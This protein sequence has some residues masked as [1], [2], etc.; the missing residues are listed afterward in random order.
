MLKHGRGS[1]Q[2]AAAKAGRSA[3]EA[4][5]NRGRA[6]PDFLAT[7]SSTLGDAAGARIDGAISAALARIAGF[8]DVDL[9]VLYEVGADAML[10]LVHYAGAPFHAPAIAGPSVSRAFPW[11]LDR[12]ARNGEMLCIN[13]IADIPG[14]AEKDRQSYARR[15][16]KAAVLIPLSAIRRC[17][18]VLAIVS[19]RPER[20]RWTR[21]DTV[22]LRATGEP[23]MHAVTRIKLDHAQRDV[24]HF[25]RF[26][27]RLSVRFAGV[28]WNRVCDEIDLALEEVLAYC[29]VDEVCIFE[30]IP[31]TKQ[32]YLRHLA[33]V[34]GVKPASK[35]LDYGALFPWQAVVTANR[36]EMTDRPGE[37]AHDAATGRFA[38]EALSMDSVLDMPI[39][40]NDEVRYVFAVASRRKSHIWAQQCIARLQT[41]G[42]V[43]INALTRI[44][45]AEAL[46]QSEQRLRE[47]MRIAHIARWQWDA[48]TDRIESSGDV[49]RIIGFEP[50]TLTK[51]M[52]SV[53]PAHRL[54]LQRSI[55]SACAKCG[56]RVRTEYIVCD[57][58]GERIIQ[59]WHEA[60]LSPNGE[61]CI[62]N[63]TIQDVTEWRKTE[64]EVDDLRAHHW[65]FDR[66]SRT[67]ILVASLAHELS[68][69]L[70]AVLSNAQA[71]LR[72]L[73]HAD[74]DPDEIRNI[75]VDIVAADKRA[76]EVLGALRAMLRRQRTKRSSLDISEAVREVL[77]LLHGELVT[78]QVQV[79]TELAADCFV[80][81]D[82]IQ[83]EQV[84]LNLLMNAVDSMR[85]QASQTRRLRL[86]VF[87]VGDDVSVAVSD[88]GIGIA[89]EHVSRIFEAFWTT[90]SKGMGMGLSVCRSI[91]ESHGGCIWVESNADR[92]VTFCVKVPAAV[93]SAPAVPQN[94]EDGARFEILTKP[95]RT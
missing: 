82:S 79:E 54:K 44:K 5:S 17:D 38:A 13:A 56:E 87:R 45:V 70:A 86:R 93:E 89:K 47:T 88:C 67:G 37:L 27:A 55:D 61:H 59:Q 85:D 30:V 76:G 1:R 32:V 65:H 43:F 83:I 18:Y 81:A 73:A 77:S 52:E 91:V 60:V 42:E 9:C 12:V 23:L 51:L 72:F 40:V 21:Q 62:L 4:V 20:S 64:Q 49:G 78:Q 15:K 48:T 16:V 36:S 46:D 66:V 19:M 92:G 10:D 69:P 75:L 3:V 31:K 34:A 35:A 90:K 2:P 71:G 53:H 41:L 7:L 68:Q 26:I 95:I 94:S 74:A 39:R 8:F 80:V 50:R 28:G 25:E 6:F 29:R 84:V 57:A 24:R 22:R 33:H 58:N 11:M 14:D 63:A